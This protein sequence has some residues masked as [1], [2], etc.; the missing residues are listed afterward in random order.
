MLRHPV[1]H[2]IHGKADF[3]RHWALAAQWS[4]LAQREEWE[5]VVPVGK[6]VEIP[7]WM[8]ES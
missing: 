4:S 7:A 5:A 3:E 2:C 8:P 6:H 1:K